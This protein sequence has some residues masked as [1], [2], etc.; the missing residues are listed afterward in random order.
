VSSK[1]LI[2]E[3]EEEEILNGEWAKAAGLS[4]S[5]TNRL[6]WEFLDAMDWNIYIGREEFITFCSQI[7]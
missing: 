7:N 3:G 2:D 4:I 1:F 6:E 5:K